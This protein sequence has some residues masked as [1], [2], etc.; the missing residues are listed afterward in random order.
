MLYHQFH[1][2]AQ[3]GQSSNYVFSLKALLLKEHISICTE[4]LRRSTAWYS[5]TQFRHRKDDFTDTAFFMM[6]F[7]EIFGNFFVCPDVILKTFWKYIMH[8]NVFV[9]FLHLFG[10]RG[11]F[12]KWSML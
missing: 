7:A 1:M 11:F 12:S 4:P 3:R 10:V 2:E 8:Y 9:F 5:E 6:F